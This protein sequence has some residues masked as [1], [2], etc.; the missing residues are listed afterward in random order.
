MGRPFPVRLRPNRSADPAEPELSVHAPD[1]TSSDS[2]NDGPELNGRHWTA[3]LSRYHWFVFI[4]AALGWLFDTMDQQL[5]TLARPL[6]MKE[7]IKPLEG[8]EPAATAAR[9]QEF[10]GYATSIFLIGWATG[11]L[12]F[13]VMGDRYGR[14]KTMLL[15]IIIY[16][17]FT[18]ISA[19]SWDFTSFAVLR[20]ITGLGVGGEF[21]VGVSLVAEVMPSRARPY[22]LSLLQALSAVG[23]ITAA[24]IG[25]SGV[26]WQ[27]MFLI[28]TAPALLSLVV[29]GRLKEPERWKSASTEEAMQKNLGSYSEL[30]SDPTLRHRALTGLVLAGAGVIGL[31]GIAFFTPDF[32]RLVLTPIFEKEELA[33]ADLEKKL[34]FYSGLSSLLLN[35]GAFFGVYLFGPVSERIGRKPTFAICF[36]LA[37]AGTMNVFWNMGRVAGLYDMYW[38][39]PL[40]GFGNLSL[41]GGYAVYFPELFPTRLRSTGTSFCYNVGRFLAAVGP[42]TLGILIRKVYSGYSV[43]AG[44]EPAMPMRLAGVTMCAVFLVGLV[45]LPFMPET[46]GKP[47]PE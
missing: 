47:L 33:G 5:F 36:L 39:L 14:V 7:L 8:E 16:S 6:A 17:I 31:W 21:A 38:M 19:Y 45:V 43:A 24:L 1:L 20:F 3:L 11:G 42:F 27:T 15:T 18:G 40:M 46:R 28:G 44:F 30:F 12:V 2:R 23:N 29:R 22:A 4:V 35:A 34:K 32:Q 25:M 41:F 37:L 9:Q 13:G 26:S 10:G